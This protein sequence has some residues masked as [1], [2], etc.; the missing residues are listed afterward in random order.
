MSGPADALAVAGRGFLAWQWLLHWNGVAWSRSYR[1][2]ASLS[3]AGSVPVGMS[4]AS[5]A[6]Q[7]WLVYT[8]VSDNSGSNAPPGPAPRPISAYFDGSLWRMVRVP[9]VGSTLAKVT[10]A[11]PDA[12]AIAGWGKQIRGILH[13]HLASGWSIQPLPHPRHYPACPPSDISAA[14]PTYVIA[15]SALSSGPCQRSFAYV[16]DGHRWRSANPHPAG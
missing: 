9:A 2:P 15:V 11:G 10:M 7:A 16:Y 6:R 4:V 3:R 13:S 8:E 14:S 12:W 5:S 1:P